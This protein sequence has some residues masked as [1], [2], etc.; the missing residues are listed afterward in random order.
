MSEWQDMQ[1]KP[2][3]NLRDLLKN[4]KVKTRKLSELSKTEQNRL[5]K[6]NLMLDKLRR[7]E[8]VQNCRLDTWLTEAE[9]EGFKIDWESQ[10]QIREELNDKPDELKRYEDKLR[11]AIFHYSRA[12]GYSAKGK[13]STAEKFY[14]S[15]ESHCE[16]ALEIL[17]EIV[18]NYSKAIELKSDYS[19]AYHNLAISLSSVRATEFSESLAENFMLILNYE[20]ITKPDNIVNSIMLLLK[21]HYTVREAI[22]HNAKNTL[23]NLTSEFCIR[24]SKIPLFLRIME[25]CLIPDL[26]IEEVLTELRRTLLLERQKLSIDN[27][28]L[29]FQKALAL[30]CF[31]NEF[32]Y[33]ETEEETF[34]I[35][36]LETRLRLAFE[37]NEQL[38]SYDL[39]CL[40][41]YRSLFDYPWA[42][43]IAPPSILEHLFK[44]QVMEVNQEL[45]LKETIPRLNVIN[46]DVSMAVQNQYEENPYPRWVNTKLSIKPL[47]IKKVMAQLELQVPNKIAPFSE[48]PQILVAGCGTGQH[49]LGTSSTFKNSHVTA[50]DLSLSSLAYAKRKTE[51]LGVTNIDYLQADI[52]DLGM[53]DKQFDIIESVG[54]LHHMADP[55]AGWKV[56]ASCLKPN[57][58]MKIGLYSEF[59]R[60]H[61][62]KLR[63]MIKQENITTTKEKMLEFRRQIIKQ[64]DAVFGTLSQSRDFYSTSTIRDLL[65]HVQEHRFTIPEIRGVLEELDLTFIGFEFSDARIKKAFKAVYPNPETIY[66]L[67]KWHEYEISNP[68]LF[69]GM[70]QFWVQKLCS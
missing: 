12:D 50:I 42:T 63:Q 41:S 31:T 20:T 37:N 58:V 22:S 11:R 24:L 55:L 43:Y 38:S 32:I 4:K 28:Y 54:V 44:R 65:F 29:L 19:E 7:G 56:L 35:Q 33:T 48:A 25:V 57:G 59:A 60:Q 10:L 34:A 51:E 27:D 47:S 62:I 26:E 13:H 40:A 6:L 52:L 45:E 9:Y 70:Y 67:N 21:H 46:D 5:A 3:T 64:D 23:E 61:I 39:A 36:T 18:S 2:N 16:D 17:Q 53:L 15:S 14:D 66:N 1:Q 8:N 30:Q 68:R 69:S 49:S